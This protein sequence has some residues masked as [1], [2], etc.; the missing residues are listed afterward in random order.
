MA[1][2]LE[3]TFKKYGRDRDGGRWCKKI[4]GRLQYFGSGSTKSDRKSYSTALK[5]YRRFCERQIIES[6]IEG[7]A[8]AFFRG[9]LKAVHG[10]NWRDELKRLKVKGSAS[11]DLET[12]MSMGD[13]LDGVDYV[14]EGEADGL[15]GPS[16]VDVM[17]MVERH[18]N[19]TVKESAKKAPG[20]VTISGHIDAWL[21][22]ERQRRDSG[23]IV[24]MSFV[25][26]QNGIETFRSFVA[27]ATFGDAPQ[28]ES[29][30]ADYRTLLLTAFNEKRYSGNTV[31][32]KTKFLGQLIKWCYQ[33]RVLN[34]LPRSL[35]QVTRKVATVKG[36][37][38]LGNAVIESLWAVA[39]D[40]MR[41]WIALA[42][43]CGFK[44]RDIGEL[45]GRD[46]VRGRLLT[47]RHK[48][49]VPMNVK[50]WPLT[51]ELLER[52][53]QDDVDPDALLFVNRVGAPLVR[54]RTDRVGYAFRALAKRAGVK[55]TFQQ[56]RDT[57]AEFV[58][59][60]CRK[61]GHA[62][63]TW[64]QLYLAHKDNS[65]AQF[66]VSNDPRDAQADVLDQAT[67]AL[68]KTMNLHAS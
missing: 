31:N 63:G 3:L 4:N 17:L 24:E 28:V 47:R 2:R 55:A 65:T 36:G 46:I 1:S 14:A 38:P 34:E 15:A 68:E 48:T 9:R 27:E 40:R 53:R 25:S 39:D 57:G 58:K 42:L 37:E 35:G 32:D 10:E 61:N 8:T 67:D 52:T 56:F 33:R 51:L 20:E 64:V 5:K 44:N 62:G 66:Y 12:G 59:S 45:T 11:G 23:D 18:A 49:G 41:C 26:K 21:E 6:E 50:L 7:S 30:L 19:R 43:N 16:L 22:N 54:D 13:G 29:L 60:W